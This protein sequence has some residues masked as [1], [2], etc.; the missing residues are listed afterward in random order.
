MGIINGRD[1]SQIEVTFDSEANGI[2]SFSKKMIH[3][4][5]QY[6]K[7]TLQRFITR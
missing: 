3:Q 7:R 5:S 2:L 1:A 4:S 6:I